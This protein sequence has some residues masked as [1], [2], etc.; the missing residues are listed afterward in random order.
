VLALLLE[1]ELGDAIAAALRE[2]GH[3]RHERRRDGEDQ[4]AL[5]VLVADV[6]A[7]GRREDH[8]E[9]QAGDDRARHARAQAAHERGGD[10]EGEDDGG[11][12]RYP[13]T[14][15]RQRLY[16]DDKPENQGRAGDLRE[17]ERR[18]TNSHDPSYHQSRCSNEESGAA[19][20]H[21]PRR[22]SRRR[23]IARRRRVQQ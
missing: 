1:G 17:R 9:P 16:Q 2:A 12:V 8:R 23:G 4:A 22:S 5:E 11:R 15:R 13:D 3:R 21:G 20:G 6:Q 19:R 14:Q 7:L 10:H 18:V